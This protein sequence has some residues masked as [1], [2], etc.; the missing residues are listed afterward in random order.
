M[1]QTFDTVLVGTDFS[2]LSELALSSA[3]AI[4]ERMSIR[5]L[6]LVHVI[7]LL[8]YPYHA[9]VGVEPYAI[10]WEVARENAAKRL[11]SA[12]IPNTTAIV[13]R[14]TRVG[15]PARELAE[16][17]SDRRADLI[18]IASH[19]RGAAARF[20]MGSV[21]ST[22]VRVAPCPVLVV[23]QERPATKVEHVLAAVDLSS[24]S[25][26]V[27]RS[28]AMVAR[29]SRAALTVLTLYEL[30][31]SVPTPSHMS[32]LPTQKERDQIEL[33]IKRR[34]ARM[35][36]PLGLPSVKVEV[37]RK[38]PAHNAILEVA[39]IVGA[40]MIVIGTSGHNA[41]QRFFLGSTATKVVAEARSPVLCVPYAVGERERALDAW[42]ST[43]IRGTNGRT[44]P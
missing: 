4:S 14:A 18:V 2:P 25:V 10:T 3:A 8:P 35:I 12:A 15:P 22:L 41:W 9:P 27:L 42:A 43:S 16:E 40:D 32:V 24:I 39:A 17:A 28:A 44:N 5:K 30:P 6:H 11:E 36:E 1:M 29:A 21:A 26:S 13:T 31:L 7:D 19:G 38:A 20:V 37:M 33:D 23:G 34:L